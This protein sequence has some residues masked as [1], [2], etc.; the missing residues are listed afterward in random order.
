MKYG[1]G[2]ALLLL[3]AALAT[4]YNTQPESQ[5]TPTPSATAVKS[6]PSTLTVFPPTL[7]PTKTHRPSFTPTATMDYPALAEHYLL[8]PFTPR[9]TIT[10]FNRFTKTNTPSPTY[11]IKTPS[12]LPTATNIP[13]ETILSHITAHHPPANW[14][15]TPPSLVDGAV[16]QDVHFT[17]PVDVQI[18]NWRVEYIQAATDLMNL[19]N[20]NKESFI[21][22]VDGW[23]ADTWSAHGYTT[24]FVENDFDHDGQAE[25]LVNIPLYSSDPQ[26]FCC[27]QLML[28]FE[29]TDGL[30]H[31]VYYQAGGGL[32]V[33]WHIMEIADLNKD[34]HLEVVTSSQYCDPSCDLATI[35]IGAWDGQRWR[36]EGIINE[37]IDFYAHILF[38]DVD[39]NGTIELVSQ[40]RTDSSTRITARIYGWRDGQFKLIETW[41]Q[42]LIDPDKIMADV[43]AALMAHKPKEAIQLAEPIIQGLRLGCEEPRDHI[44]LLVI[45]AY[46]LDG[47]Q[48]AAQDTLNQMS[49]FCN[50]SNSSNVIP[51]GQVFWVAYQKTQNPILAC[52]TMDRFVVDKMP[53]VANHGNY[54][55]YPLCPGDL[56]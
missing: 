11:D 45:F 5:L 47:Q 12:P 56:K 4:G 17:H 36:N 54:K 20:A 10:P 16:V 55:H 38:V 52:Q 22:Y 6:T 29:K 37:L 51:L 14:T 18:A 23:A 41:L 48:Q 39:D 31:P 32:N 53:E 21:K 19:T 8:T 50:Y 49:K 27:S 3:L 9:P 40:G 46:T 43:H 34:G 30:Y 25:W 15:P 28:L 13:D 44:S 7:S 42:P 33:D 1:Y 26:A 24:W 35:K 2:L